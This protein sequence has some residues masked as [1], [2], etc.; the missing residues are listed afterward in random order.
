MPSTVGKKST[1]ITSVPWYVEEGA[2]ATLTLRFLDGDSEALDIS[3]YTWRADGKKDAKDNAAYV[4]LEVSSGLTLSDS[5]SGTTDQLEIVLPQEAI[6]KAPDGFYLEPR[7]VASGVVL[8]PLRFFVRLQEFV[9]E[10]NYAG[11]DLD[12]GSLVVTVGGSG[13]AVVVT[14]TG[15][16]SSAGIAAE[17]HSKLSTLTATRDFAASDAGRR[18]VLDG[19][20]LTLPASFAPDRSI[21]VYNPS[22]AASPQDVELPGGTLAVQPGWDVELVWKDAS[23]AD[24]FIRNA[25]TIS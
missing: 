2:D 7:G 6:E 11:A 8:R 4:S 16:T 19:F 24:A 1:D 18:I 20:G 12:A 22:D 15:G 17:T 23:H 14:V 5:G 10:G 25:A 13:A 3:G 21:Y 9:T